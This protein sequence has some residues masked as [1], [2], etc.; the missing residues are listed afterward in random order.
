[1]DLLALVA[2]FDAVQNVCRQIWMDSLVLTGLLD[3][4]EFAT[5]GTV[6]AHS[7]TVLECFQFP[8]P[9]ASTSIS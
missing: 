7:D 5:S 9:I 1:M 6:V 3:S 2:P 8:Q 4:S